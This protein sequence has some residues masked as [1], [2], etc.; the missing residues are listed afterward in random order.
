MP[1]KSFYIFLTS[2]LGMLLF[3]V[4]HRVISFLLL[5]SA[6]SGLIF[7]NLDF[8]A[9]ILTDYITLLVSLMLGAW[10]GIWL[11]LGWFE[12]VYEQKSHRGLVD[13]LAMKIFSDDHEGLRAKL[14]A[15]EKQLEDD[16]V[17][18]LSKID[19]I[20]QASWAHAIH[21]AHFKSLPVRRTVARK[22]AVSKPKRKKTV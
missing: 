19:H 20:A 21:S 18:D 11:G 12:K 22:R 1:K 5:Y 13:H 2:L 9:F 15:A 16:V 17:K 6:A 14:I 7:R 8:Q 3:L 4:I 10:Y